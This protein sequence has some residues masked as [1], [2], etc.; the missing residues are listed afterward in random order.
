MFARVCFF[1]KSSV[2]PT[3]MTPLGRWCH[4]SSDMYKTTC[5]QEIKAMLNNRDHGH[6]DAPLTNKHA[7]K[8][9]V[10]RDPVTVFLYAC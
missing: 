5:N 10:E 8:S 7:I 6:L 3:N 9:D 4:P 2:T 1:F